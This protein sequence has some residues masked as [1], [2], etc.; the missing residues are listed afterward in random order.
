MA[1]PIISKVREPS[2][3]DHFVRE[4]ESTTKEMELLLESVRNNSSVEL[5]GM[6]KDLK[7]ILATV[8]DLQKTIR[9]DSGTSGILERIVKLEERLNH[10]RESL[11]DRNESTGEEKKA[12]IQGNWSVKVATIGSLTALVTTILMIIVQIILKK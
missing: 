1:P 5:A 10:T 2:K 7:Y 4:M 8:T 9:G 6:E 12:H 11:V 3:L